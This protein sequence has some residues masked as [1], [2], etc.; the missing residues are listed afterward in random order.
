LEV[1]MARTKSSRDKVR[2][3]PIELLKKSG[4]DVE[5]EEAQRERHAAAERYLGILTGRNQH[6]AE[7]AREAVR[8]QLRRRYGR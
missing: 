1:E 8:K 7:T 4:L 6:K 3:H 2:A 5:G